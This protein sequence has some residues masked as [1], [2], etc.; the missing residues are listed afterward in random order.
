MINALN[1]KLQVIITSFRLLKKPTQTYFLECKML[2]IKYFRNT[3]AVGLET[4]ESF[5]EGHLHKDAHCRQWTLNRSPQRGGATLECARSLFTSPRDCSYLYKLMVGLWYMHIYASQ[6][7]L[8]AQPWILLESKECRSS[9]DIF[10]YSPTSG[11]G[12]T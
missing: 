10:K 4:H 3:K 8:R 12:V 7:S 9:G 1:L 11:Q 2:L 6:R 5:S